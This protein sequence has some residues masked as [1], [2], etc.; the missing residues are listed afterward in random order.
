MWHAVL[1]Q[2]SVELVQPK[3]VGGGV[4]Q[5]KDGKR[6]H[7]SGKST[8][9]RSVLFI[10]AKMEQARIERKN[11]EKIDAAGRDAMFGDDDINFDLQLEK[12]G[13]DVAALKEAPAQ[14]IFRAWVEDWEEE[15]RKKNDPV[16]EAR[17]LQKY[18]G[19][20]FFDPDTSSTFS[21]WEQNMEFHR[22]KGN[23]WFLLAVNADCDNED[24]EEGELEAFS[25]ELAIELIAET[26]QD[27]GVQV[28]QQQDD[29]KET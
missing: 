27:I 17:L 19:L 21:I 14:R 9:K 23:G 6:S 26:Q 3:E 12:F 1:H 24:G 2:N 15:A 7:M 10:T 28:V 25:L 4:K 8:E 20:V 5:V 22:G 18:K 13:V 16:A 11:L 29:D